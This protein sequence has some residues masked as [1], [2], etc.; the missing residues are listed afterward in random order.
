[1][2]DHMSKMRVSR[3]EFEATVRKAARGADWPAALAEDLSRAAGALAATGGKG[4]ELGLSMVEGDQRDIL[5]ATIT[6]FELSLGGEASAV[7]DAPSDLLAACALS[8]GAEHGVGFDI[9]TEGNGAKIS[10]DAK[11]SVEI[12]EIFVAPTVWGSLQKL[13]HKSYVLASAKSRLAGAGAGLTDN[14]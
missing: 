13:A 7:T 2:V 1:M 14:D 10:A 3:S 4:G 12:V 5:A 11:K 9:S 8:M 6:A